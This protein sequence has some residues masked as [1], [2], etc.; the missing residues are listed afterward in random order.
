[1]N[2]RQSFQPSCPL[3]GQWYVCETGSRFVGCC[4][5]DPCNFGC[6]QGDLKPASFNPALHG[7]FPDL[8]C[9]AA[10]FY[11]CNATS[12]P[13]M[14][15]CKSNPCRGGRGCPTLDLAAAY[16][17]TNEAEACQFYDRGCS[18]DSPSTTPSIPTSTPSASSST[19]VPQAAASRKSSTGPIVGG[20][21][22]GVLGLTMVMILLFYCYRH[23]AKSRRLRSEMVARNSQQ[24][25]GNLPA[26]KVFLEA[27]RHH[28][29]LSRILHLITFIM[30]GATSIIDSSPR[31]QS[32]KC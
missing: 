15:C 11:T 31:L 13:F 26:T 18:P 27:K 24:S 29:G 21:V 2:R 3:G 8:L 30:K 17:S 12:P 16:L 5:N 20:V 1:M 10:A 4:G 19:T 9:S 7:L 32:L 25:M 28:E 14:G 22:G 23:S 6:K